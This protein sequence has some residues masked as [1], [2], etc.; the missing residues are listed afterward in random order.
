[1]GCEVCNSCQDGCEKSFQ[2]ISAIKGEQFYFRDYYGETF[3][4]N[5]KFLTAEEWNRLITYIIEGYELIGNVTTEDSY[6][7]NDEA[8]YAKG[9]SDPEYYDGK[10]QT[11]MTAN[12]Y[13]G[14]L[15]K[16][17]FLSGEKPSNPISSGDLIQA[18]YF[19]NLQEYAN[20]YFGLKNGSTGRYCEDCQGTNQAT[21]CCDE[22]SGGGGGTEGGGCTSCNILCNSNQCD[23]ETLAQ[24]AQSIGGCWES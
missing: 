13:N 10:G 24:C 17:E 1:M 23:C 22:S 6:K 5:D 19:N 20:E 18:N 16:M 12:M 14:A 4:R 7:Y 9:V 11:I 15:A 21:Y 3:E 8:I 2:K